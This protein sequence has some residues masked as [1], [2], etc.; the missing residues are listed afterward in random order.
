M[1]CAGSEDKKEGGVKVDCVDMPPSMAVF[2]REGL[3]G[4]PV[5]LEKVKANWHDD[6]STHPNG[7]APGEM[8]C[9]NE[10]AVG[11][12]AYM[13]A[14]IPDVKW[15]TH[16]ILH[17]KCAKGDK[18]IHIGTATGTPAMPGPWGEPTG[19]SFHIMAT[20]IHH[21]VDGKLYEAWHVEDFAEAAQQL[22]GD[23]EGIP[24]LHGGQPFFPYDREGDYDGKQTAP[25]KEIKSEDMPRSLQI[26]YREFLSNP[27]GATDEL[28]AEGFNEKWNS[29]P[30][31]AAPG[32][33]GPG[34]GVA[35]MVSG[36]FGNVAP[37]L[38]WTTEHVYEIPCKKGFKYVHCGTGAAVPVAPGPWGE[39]TGKGFNIMAIDVAHVVD[40]KNFETWHV[41]EFHDAAAQL[42]GEEE[43]PP[44]HKGQGLFK[45][46][47]DRIV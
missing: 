12:V 3:C 26:F 1:G 19:K 2:Y 41:E 17:V 27:K 7:V 21:I 23:H 28:A 5:D 47:A 43:S 36:F 34:L 4:K 22:K 13:Q 42:L 10:S 16:E 31:L 25:G 29:H 8:T 32:S 11:L 9:N 35:G 18:Y 14:A 37:D 44:L 38:K 39:P 6:W 46:G 24:E 30:N 20:D 15:T 45:D 40:G 33:P